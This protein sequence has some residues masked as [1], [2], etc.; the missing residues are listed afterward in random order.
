MEIGTVIEHVRHVA[1]VRTDGT[2]PTERLES[3]LRDVGRLEAWLAGTKAALTSLLA[4][5]VSF[6]EKTIADCTRGSTRDAINDTARA[7]TLDAAPS[8]A[9]ALDDA[10]VTVGHVDAVTKATKSL[11]ADQR[12]ELLGRLDT[13]LLDIAAVATVAE[14]R[15]RLAMEVNNIQ[16]DDGIDRF[17]RQQ[18]ATSV[19]SWTDGEG[20]WCL[21][22][23]FDPVTGVKLSAAIDA[24]T[25]ALF[26]EQT[27]T[28]CPTDPVEKQRH[29]NALALAGLITDAGGT[30]R[31]GR[32]EY[33]VVVDTSQPDG[34]GGPE[35]DWGIPV[36]VP[37]RV[38][39]ELMG[40]G[41]VE[42]VIV[43]NRVVLHAPG[44]LN[45]GR[46]TRLANRAQRRALR[47]LY[48][49]CAIPGCDVRYDRCKL[50]HIVWWRNGGRTDLDNLLPVCTHHHTKIHD[51]GWQV[52]LGAN[53]ELTITFPD[54]TIHNTGPPSR[55]AA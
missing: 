38:L 19:R 34:A 50:H 41:R 37:H 7:G 44:E 49:S 55:R 21:S 36:E 15:R 32:P 46:T 52:S 5:Q 28:T 42:T 6:P 45:L 51:A 25:N 8:L 43:R 9:D 17:E 16:R 3:A 27:P 33:V 47:A 23:R 1:D 31:P 48:S 26:A 29:L 10:R 12:D 30:G 4:A 40:D 20:M 2:A 18:R 39:A 24:A 53:R 54:G 13:G 22:G 35:V 14:W 11:D